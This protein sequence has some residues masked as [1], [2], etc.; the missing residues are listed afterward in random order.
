MHAAC[1]SNITLSEYHYLLLTYYMSD[2]GSY[3]VDAGGKRSLDHLF[4]FG[5]G[6]MTFSPDTEWKMQL[7]RKVLIGK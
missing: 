4:I 7:L 1:S 3:T 2:A 6:R 5:E